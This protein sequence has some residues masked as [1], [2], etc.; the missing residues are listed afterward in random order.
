M[1][2]FNYISNI[3]STIVNRRI[4][5]GFILYLSTLAALFSIENWI[6]LSAISILPLLLLAL[7]DTKLS[8][9]TLIPVTFIGW[10]IIEEPFTLKPVDVITIL[11]IF[12]FLFYKLINSDF[13]FTIDKLQKPIL[14]FIFAISI[15]LIDTADIQKSVMNLFKHL[16]L[17]VLYFIITNSFSSWKLSNIKHVLDYFLYVSLSATIIAII[18]LINSDE[19]RA[20]GI[21]GIPLAELTVGALIISISFFIFSNSKR[22]TIKYALFSLLLFTG[23]VLTQTR[24]AWI[25]FFLSLAFMWFLVRKK[26]VGF[27]RNRL[28]GILSILLLSVMITFLVFPNIF[29][30][31]AHRV[32]EIKH[33]EIGTIQLRLILWEAAIRAFLSHPINGIGLGQFTVLSENFSSL[34]MSSIFKENVGGLSAHNITF[35]YLSETGLIGII[36]LIIFYTSMLK[37]ARN[38]FIRAK[39]LQEIEISTALFTNLFFVVASST[40]AGS[41]FW[42]L[43]GTQFMIFLA[44]STI[45]S[46]KIKK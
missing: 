1:S 39:N 34:G 29:T 26:S 24:G 10:L 23:L 28:F 14:I 32:E 25:S 3:N 41:W 37:L 30:L 11:M 17:F 33:F 15:S 21:T 43:N 7:F 2:H 8:L 20:F 27:S 4:W 36:G 19:V 18:L 38:T 16:E 40:Y 9:Y 45:V 31:I 46:N 12:S 35:S 13:T 6:I 22:T 44:L 42:G 5:F